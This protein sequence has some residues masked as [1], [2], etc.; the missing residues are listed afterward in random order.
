MAV[1]DGVVIKGRPIVIHE[2]LQQK[3]IKQLHINHMGIK[4]H[5]L[6]HKTVYWIDMNVDIENHI[7][8]CSPCI[9][10]Q[11]TQPK[12]KV[13]HHDIPG[14]PWE[15]IGTDMFTLN[16]KNLPFHCRLSQQISNCEKA[17]DTSANSLILACKAIFQNMYCQRK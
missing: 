5:P 1:I 16:N 2:A 10:S 15:I 12:E 11:K 4:T 7:K 13:I 17:E 14:K 3:V 8:N 9:N 6:G